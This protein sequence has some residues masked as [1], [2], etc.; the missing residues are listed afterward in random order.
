MQMITAVL[1]IV[2]YLLVGIVTGGIVSL[3]I[4]R[5]HCLQ[6]KTIFMSF[7]LWPIFWSLW[8]I[9]WSFALVRVPYVG[10]ISVSR[11]VGRMIG[12]LLQAVRG[13]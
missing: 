10:I 13:K 8:L 4:P 5:D 9:C 12:R 6:A 2:G 1:L 11:L 7:L 3:L